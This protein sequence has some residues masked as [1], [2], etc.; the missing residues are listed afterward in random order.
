MINGKIPKLTRRQFLTQTLV[1]ATGLVLVACAAPPTQSGAVPAA[2]QPEAA[3]PTPVPTAAVS[4][5]GSGERELVFWHGLGGAD[6]KTMTQ[7]LERYTEENPDITVRQELLPWDVF[8]QKLP[9]SVIAGTPPDMIITHEWAIGQFGSREMLRSAEE[10]YTERGLDKSDFLPFAMNNVTYEGEPLGVLLDN[11]GYA[12][13]VNAE[14]LEEAGFDSDSPPTSGSEWLEMALQLTRDQSGKTAAESGFDPENI[15]TYAYVFG[16]TRWGPLSA[17]WQF[18]GDTISEDGTR[19]T[20]GD[21]AAHEA[22]Q[23]LHDAIYKQHVIPVPV[24]YGFRDAYSNRKLAMYSHGSWDLNFIRDQNLESI[25]KLWP[26]PHWGSVGP[27]VWMSAHVMATPTGVD[28]EGAELAAHLTMWLSEHGLDWA[29]SGQPPARISQQNN[30]EL[31]QHWHTGN[32]ARQF[33]EIGRTERQH[34]NIVE[35]QRAYH[36]EFDAILT[37]SKP[38]DQALTDADDRIQRILERTA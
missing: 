19:S 38:I 35:I 10:F 11:H 2:T 25:T 5:F 13:Y 16:N 3:G 29:K 20:I 27:A 9:T 24:G 30:A 34:P 36:P 15:D 12:T 8:Y 21:E 4:E 1:G 23:A 33:Q 22:L 37:N 32:V 31:Q 17:L 28:D 26:M 14:L 6:G 7:L 18:G